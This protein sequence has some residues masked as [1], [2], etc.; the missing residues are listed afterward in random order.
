LKEVIFMFIS[1]TLKESCKRF[2]LPAFLVVM[3]L[4]QPANTTAQ[5]VES[6]DVGIVKTAVQSPTESGTAATYIIVVDSLPSGATFVSAETTGATDPEAAVLQSGGVVNAYLGT[7]A[8]GASTTITINAILRGN[9]RTINTATVRANGTC[10]ADPT[11]NF[12]S[13][14]VTQTAGGDGPGADLEITKVDRQDPIAVDGLLTYDIEVVNTGPADAQS[15]VITDKIPSGTDFVSATSS[16]TEGFV[17]ING[18]VT[19]LIGDLANGEAAN[20]SVT[21][22]PRAAGLI[23]NAVSARSSTNSSGP[24]QDNTAVQYTTVTGFPLCACCDIQPEVDLAITKVDTPDPAVVGQPLTYTITVSNV[25]L[26]PATGVLVT[27]ELPDNVVP[28]S[29]SITPSG[30]CNRNGRTITCAVGTLLPGA[31]SVITLEV[32]PTEA[33]SL[34]NTAT[35]RANEPDSNMANNETSVTETTVSAANCIDLTGMFKMSPETQCT[36]NKKGKVTCT[37]YAWFVLQNIGDQ[38]AKIATVQFYMS[39]DILFDAG[40]KKLKSY[41]FKKVAPGAMIQVD[42]VFKKQR[43]AVGNYIIAVIDIKNKI[44]ECNEENNIVIS[45]PIIERQ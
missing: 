17:E 3:G 23:V 2:A 27:D 44:I 34:H 12:A 20:V 15:V 22:R 21:V 13:A 26:A 35:V 4:V 32:I 43:D 9:G 31:S 40:D 29:H 24:L 16:G 37:V 28:V 10:D 5:T 8:P 30:A 19:Y 36:T 18:I 7:M 41:K 25:G 1:H 14:E 38:T 11:N 39:D 42:P 6:A 45:L 33:G